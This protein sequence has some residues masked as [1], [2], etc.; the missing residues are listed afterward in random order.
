ML[1]HLAPLYT[2]QFAD[3]GTVGQPFDSVDHAGC[4]EV[5][6][7]CNGHAYTMVC[8]LEESGQIYGEF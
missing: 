7:I 5:P 2:A 3:P 1:N 4:V 6:F 8:W